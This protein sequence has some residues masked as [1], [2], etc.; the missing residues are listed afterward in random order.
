MYTTLALTLQYVLLI[1]IGLRYLAHLVGDNFR[2]VTNG[3]FIDL[4]FTLV[5]DRRN[6]DLGLEQ[7][8]FFNNVGRTTTYTVTEEFSR[9][10]EKCIM[11]TAYIFVRNLF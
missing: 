1:L 5:V 4:T 3:V 9:N 11:Q 6:S 2:Y 7:R 8:V 10:Q